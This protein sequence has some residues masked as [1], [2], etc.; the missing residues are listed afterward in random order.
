MRKSLTI[1][2]AAAAILLLGAGKASAQWRYGNT[3]S[4]GYYYNTPYNWNVSLG[5]GNAGYYYS[6]GYYGGYSYPTYNYSNYYGGYRYSY[7]RYYGGYYNYPTYRQYPYN[8]YY[9][10]G[11][12]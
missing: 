8:S 1:L 2:I 10:R 6:P 11:R 4:S 7:P 3:Y 12:W 9:R 5:F